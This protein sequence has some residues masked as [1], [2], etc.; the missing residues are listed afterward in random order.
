MTG[1]DH[2]PRVFCAS[3]CESY[4]KKRDVWQ[5]FSELILDDFLLVIN[6]E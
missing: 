2:I 5:A 4:N 1:R 3:I 6:H